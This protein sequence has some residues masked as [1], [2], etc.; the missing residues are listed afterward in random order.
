MAK[1]LLDIHCIHEPYCEYPVAV[2]ITMDDGTVQ[3]Y[4]LEHRTDYMFQKVMES[5]D[6]MTV[7]YQHKEEPP[8]RRRN[9]IHRA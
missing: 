8:K 6:R 2:R 4:N 1:P 5:L 7:G 3:T 9:R